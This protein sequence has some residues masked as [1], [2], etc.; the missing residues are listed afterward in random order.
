M[1]PYNKLQGKHHR[2]TEL[3]ADQQRRI[4]ELEAKLKEIQAL[5][6]LATDV[7]CK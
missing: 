3:C 7:T 1:T 5:L 4:K 2:L 6:Q